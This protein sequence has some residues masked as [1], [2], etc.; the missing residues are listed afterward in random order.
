[1]S[2][3]WGGIIGS[4]L[5]GGAAGAMGSVASDIGDQQ[6]AALQRQ[7]D[8]ALAKLQRESH[9]V[10]LQQTA[11]SAIKNAPAVAAA[12]RDA[13]A[14]QTPL[15]VDRAK[16]IDATK[17][18]N[19][20]RIIPAGSRLTD[21][22]GNVLV[23][24]QEK[25]QT[26]EEK[27]KIASEIANLNASAEEHRA[28]AA[29][30]RAAA[31]NPKSDK[32]TKFDVPNWQPAPQFGKGG[33]AKNWSYDAN[34]GT[35]KH[36]IPGQAAVPE[37]KGLVNRWLGTGSDAKPAK[38]PVVE[39]FTVGDDG[40]LLPMTASE[41]ASR[42]PKSAQ[43]KAQ[44]DE[45]GASTPAPAAPVTPAATSKPAQPQLV[46]PKLNTAPPD[47]TIIRDKSGQRYKV[48]NGVP[49]KI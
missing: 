39:T 15:E 28:A 8:E 38:A 6:K 46:P 24:A 40:S 9:A 14:Q 13:Y 1:M 47:G 3:S 35:V 11:D 2:M 25:P 29:K 30:N 4:A 41:Y 23:D 34:S 44:A 22:E 21:N 33:D 43:G 7:R 32:T 18:E 42:Y 16:Q 17:S 12:Q 27:A 45:S 10:E 5:A 48:I 31:E 49:V 37:D 36:V 26:P 20:T 19:R